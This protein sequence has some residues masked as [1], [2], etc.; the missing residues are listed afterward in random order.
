MSKIFSKTANKVTLMSVILAV[1]L[2]AALVI[3]AIFGFNKDVTLKDSTTLTVSMNKFAY[4]QSSDVVIEECEKM[5]PLKAKY[6]LKGETSG[7]ECQIVF[8]F[9][10]DVNINNIKTKVAA[11]YEAKT[12][13]GAAWD[14][15]SIDVSAQSEKATGVIAKHFTLRTAIAAAVMAV[16]AFAYVAARNKKV[17]VGIVAGVSV[18]LGMALTAGLIVLT[19][20]PVTTNVAAII[21]VA[22]LLTA[23]SVMLTIGKTR[24]A[25]RE[26][27]KTL[28]EAND[29]AI[30][31]SIAAKETLLLAG[32][33]TIGV[34]LVGALGGLGGIWF[35]LAA[36]VGILSFTA[37][38]LFFAPA[39]YCSVQKLA[40]S[41][42][43]KTG[44]VGAKKTSAKEKKARPA[45][46][47]AKAEVV[48]ESVEEITEEPAAEVVEEPVEEV[49]EEPAAE[50]VEESVE[51][52]AEEPVAEV[53]EESVEEVAEEPAEE[54]EKDENAEA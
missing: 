4:T 45:K 6:V 26:T 2:A 27:E 33:L 14:G 28:I 46:K 21:T 9:H 47:A 34:I 36:L 42:A 54:V 20:I 38:S 8:V 52:V 24:A 43:K 35:G 11:Y 15:V 53:V 19:R 50:V 25:L 3:G 12:A 1:I 37:I 18:F 5:F 17:S 48:E 31:S 16:A 51:E 22:G 7:D 13:D 29:E 10:K 32:G 23:V 40:S 30:V 41:I 44:Y 39:T 49:A